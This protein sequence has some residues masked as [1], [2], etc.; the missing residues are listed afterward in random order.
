M[1]VNFSGLGLI[2]DQ[3]FYYHG[4]LRW[5]YGWATPNYAGAFLATIEPIIWLSAGLIYNKSRPKTS[6]CFQFA[7]ELAFWF[8]LAR[9]YSRGSIVA[10]FGARATWQATRGDLASIKKWAGYLLAPVACI[11]A[12]GLGGR[13]YNTVATADPSV[14]HRLELWTAGLRMLAAS[15]WTGWGAGKSGI[16]YMN[17]YEP[18]GH[19]EIFASMV[20][21]YLSL[22]VEHGLPVFCLIIFV[23][24]CLVYGGISAAKSAAKTGRAAQALALAAAAS[25]CV[26]WS[27]ANLFTN[28]WTVPSLWIVPGAAVCVMAGCRGTWQELGADKILRGVVLSLGAGLLLFI[29]GL[30][31]ERRSP[32]MIRHGGHDTIT[33]EP[34]M[35]SPED[36]R[37]PAM[38]IWPDPLVLG[39][40]PGRQFRAWL[41]QPDGPERLVVR[42]Q[43]G[44]MED[45]TKP[46]PDKRILVFTGRQASCLQ[47]I[48]LFTSDRI[49]LLHPVKLGR[50]DLGPLRGHQAVVVLPAIDQAGTNDGVKNKAGALGA[51]ILFSPGVGLDLGAVWP[52]IMKPAVDTL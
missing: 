12:G 46:A 22:A 23:L 41:L 30:A 8:M 2:F 33:L 36:K 5:S 42:A 47:A 26:A 38:E 35:I 9:T 27:A 39:A 4:R 37:L 40:F 29:A 13:I 16:M 15:P 11:R 32:V 50:E 21:S 1:P 3:A 25:V 7:T 52:G 20:N 6:G 10:A 43:T 48:Q 51:K 18:P 31:L 28:L 34:R 19:T 49:I 44:D 14:E 24:G 45:G 17:W